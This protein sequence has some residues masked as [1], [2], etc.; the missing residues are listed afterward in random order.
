LSF[1][2]SL[3]QGSLLR[4]HLFSPVVEVPQ[5]PQTSVPTT[6]PMCS[7]NDQQKNCWLEKLETKHARLTAKRDELSSKL[8]DDAL[9]A[10]R[11]R[12]ITWKL[13]KVQE[14]ISFIETRKQQIS[15]NPQEHWKGGRG[16]GRGGGCRRN[17]QQHQ[18]ANQHQQPK[19][20]CW[21]EWM[22]KRQ[23]NLVAKRDS[24][25][26]K[27]AEGG[28]QM[29]PERRNALNQKLQMIQEKINAIELRKQQLAQKNDQQD[30]QQQ[31]QPNWMEKRHGI[32]VAKRESINAKLNQGGDQMKPERRS[33]LNLKLQ[34]VEQK[35]NCIEIKKQQLTQQGGVGCRGGRGGRGCGRGAR[36]NVE[37]K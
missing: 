26:A 21:S 22:E 30:Q 31:Q 2:L 29:E 7:G 36:F 28:D 11:R 16:G 4:L 34:M 1:A 3:N 6:T 24:I 37:K 20:Q 5:I 23:T 15:Q 32:L 25:N 17:Q 18:E 14:K 12:V 33:A 13:E 27:L 35:I 10:D 19:E 8:A 9:N